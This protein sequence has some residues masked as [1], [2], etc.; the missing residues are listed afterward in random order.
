[1]RT[2]KWKRTFRLF[3]LFCFFFLKENLHFV[4][5][6]IKLTHYWQTKIV[7]FFFWCVYNEI[8]GSSS[9]SIIRVYENTDE[10]NE[11]IPIL[12]SKGRRKIVLSVHSTLEKAFI[13]SKCVSFC[14]CLIINIPIFFFFLHV[15][16]RI[17]CSYYSNS[18]KNTKYTH[19]YYDNT[20]ISFY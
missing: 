17:L 12:F 2:T 14:F 4:N 18:Q 20:A 11:C 19:R 6:F 8:I 3:I 15:T 9:S 5:Q 16:T 7:F 10:K 13:L 1:M